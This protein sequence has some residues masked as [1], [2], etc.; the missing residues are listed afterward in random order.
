[1][2]REALR[3]DSDGHDERYRLE[4]TM[5]ITRERPADSCRAVLIGS[6]FL[7]T[8]FDLSSSS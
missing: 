8:N 1:M 4:P 7:F 6:G 3:F 2:D 5:V